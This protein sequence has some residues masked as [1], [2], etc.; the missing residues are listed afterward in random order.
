MAWNLWFKQGLV[1]YSPFMPRI[2][3]RSPIISIHLEKVVEFNT[4]W[5]TGTAIVKSAV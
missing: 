5:L 1:V 4:T 2:V 3:S